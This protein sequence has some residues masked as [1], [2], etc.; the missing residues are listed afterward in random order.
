MIDFE[1]PLMNINVTKHYSTFVQ[2]SFPTLEYDHLSEIWT[3]M[4]TGAKATIRMRLLCNV[5]S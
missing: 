1:I 3:F 2:Y 5:S 4:F